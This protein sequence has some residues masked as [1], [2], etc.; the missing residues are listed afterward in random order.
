MRVLL[1]RQAVTTETAFC[2][3][4]VLI[5]LQLIVFGS[6]YTNSIVLI[7]L[8][9]A[10]YELRKPLISFSSLDGFFLPERTAKALTP[11]FLRTSGITTT[12]PSE[13]SGGLTGTL[14]L[15]RPYS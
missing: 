11:C 10:S 9:S 1:C 6:E 2:L 12:Q 4:S 15:R 8:Y 7:H 3:S 13:T 5:T 14:Y